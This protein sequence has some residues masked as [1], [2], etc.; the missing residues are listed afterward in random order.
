MEMERIWDDP[1]GYR[2]TPVPAA[3]EE[4]VWDGITPFE[5]LDQSVYTFIT[6]APGVDRASLQEEIAVT[7]NIR[8][9]L[10]S[11]AEQ[12]QQKK[13]YQTPVLG[14]KS[15]FLIKGDI[16][17]SKLNLEFRD[18]IWYRTAME[19]GELNV[20]AGLVGAQKIFLPLSP[21]MPKKMLMNNVYDMQ[22]RGSAKK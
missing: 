13:V 21:M 8:D 18:S 2:R 11:F 22:L 10:V 9:Y 5:E 12:A 14:T 19:K 7:S 15:G 6:Y 3:T 16:T 1:E 20:T 4:Q 17:A